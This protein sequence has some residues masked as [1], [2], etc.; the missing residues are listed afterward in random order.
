MFSFPEKMM[1]MDE[2]GKYMHAIAA[3]LRTG[4]SYTNNSFNGSF[5]S[6]C[7]EKSI[8]HKLVTLVSLIIGGCG[9]ENRA[10]SQQVLTI[11]QLIQTNFHKRET[12]DTHRRLVKHRETPAAIYAALKIYS[13]VRSK[14]LIDHFVNIG[15]CI[16]YDR[17]LEEEYLHYYCKR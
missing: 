6:N 10:Y 17:L 9:V 7:Q 15:L 4:L 3:E 14:V 8:P 11:V 5:T 1:T 12:A 13:T 16:S 2:F